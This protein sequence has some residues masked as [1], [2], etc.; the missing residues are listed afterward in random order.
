MYAHGGFFH[1]QCATTVFSHA[2]FR[3]LDLTVAGSTAK[4]SNQFVNLC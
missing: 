2:D 1:A 4:L 3:A